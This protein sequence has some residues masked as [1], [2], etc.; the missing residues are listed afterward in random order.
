MARSSEIK[1]TNG[2][3]NQLKAISGK[4]LDRRLKREIAIRKLN[5]SRGA[6]RH[7][8]IVNTNQINGMEPAG[9]KIWRNGYGGS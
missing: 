2:V 4:T 8:S 1:L 6:I 7:G 3:R 9:A 5:R